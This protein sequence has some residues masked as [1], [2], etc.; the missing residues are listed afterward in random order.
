[1]IQPRR[2]RAT[3]RR[4]ERWLLEQGSFSIEEI[5]FGII[6]KRKCTK[7]AKDLVMKWSLRAFL[8]VVP[9]MA[10]MF[11]WLVQALLEPKPEETVSYIGRITNGAEMFLPEP[12]S[13][14]I[15][16]VIE[17]VVAKGNIRGKGEIQKLVY[18]SPF[19]LEEVEAWIDP[20]RSYPLIGP[21]Q[22]HH[23]LWKCNFDTVDK[24]GE[25]SK[26]AIL[27]D[28]NHFHMGGTL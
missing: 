22:L 8:I 25:I 3:Q 11:A 13:D 6:A 4:G 15:V 20:E 28:Q 16:R 27:I 7:R 19:E 17:K 9:I 18:D 2:Q 1:M 26:R 14:E 24:D 21:A 10:L 23:R 12:T 5:K